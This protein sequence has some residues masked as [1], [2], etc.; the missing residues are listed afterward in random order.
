[1]RARHVTLTLAAALVPTVVAAQALHESDTQEPRRYGVVRTMLPPAATSTNAFAV[2]DFDGDGA[3]DIYATGETGA[4]NDRLFH[5]EGAGAFLDESWRLPNTSLPGLDAAASDLD[6]DGWCDLVVGTHSVSERLYR[7][8]GGVFADAS[9]ALPPDPDPTR[10]VAL[11][12]VDGDG[13]LDV[14]LGDELAPCRLYFNDGFGGFAD[15]SASIPSGAY[16][17]T[18]V[19]LGDVDGDGDLDAA[20]A[21]GRLCLGPSMQDRLYLNDGAGAFSEAT[22]RLPADELLT[23]AVALGDVDG[24]LDLDLLFADSGDC[25]SLGAHDRLYKNDGTGTFVDATADLASEELDTRAC[26]LGDVDGDG[27]LDALLGSLP[28]YGGGFPPIVVPGVTSLHRND[29]AGVFGPGEDVPAGLVEGSSCLALADV[30][31]DGDLDAFT[32]G[33]LDRLHLNDG[34]G[35]FALIECVLPPDSLEPVALGDVDADGHLDLLAYTLI[36]T[37]V[38]YHPYEAEHRLFLGDDAGYFAEAFGKL[39]DLEFPFA[40]AA[41]GDVDGDG[42]E[43]LLLACS[44]DGEY[45][46][47]VQDNLLYLS[48]GRGAFTDATDQLPTYVGD[49][50]GVAQCVR[51]ADVDDDGDLDAVFAEREDY[52]GGGGGVTL[53][54][55]D[56]AGWFSDATA[57]VACMLSEAEFVECGDVDADGDVDLVAG[58][59]PWWIGLMLNDGTG[60]FADGSAQLPPLAEAGDAYLFFGLGDVNGDHDLDI[61][62][63]GAA[64]Y[65]YQY[66][67]RL[68]ANDGAGVFVEAS[69]GMPQIADDYLLAD[70]DEDGDL[71]LLGGDVLLA[72]DGDGA[73]HVQP[74]QIPPW[75]SGPRRLGDVDGDGDLDA[76]VAMGGQDVVWSNLTRH[77]T[78][79]GPPRIGKSLALDVYG[80]P[81]TPWLLAVA[82]SAASLPLPP[83]GTLALDPALLSLVGSGSLDA[84]GRGTAYF[85]V[86]LDPGLV[87]AALQ[88]QALV[89]APPRFT[90]REVTVFTDL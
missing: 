36:P 69:A 64:L 85:S 83:Y 77:L 75:L 1:M 72:N 31:G 29:G 84:A 80:A 89:G 76:V 60:R 21:V 5:N 90:N 74:G 25:D 86:P 8:A 19:A 35:A 56:R 70:V 62:F 68:Y 13:D 88:W 54:R 14:W 58:G 22:D 24:D 63:G 59:F 6:G 52:D 18:D 40:D 46:P 7:N 50:R 87:G 44:Y 81:Q 78:W 53:F 41:L 79:R 43:D 10:A 15:A 3:P 34:A 11:G 65:S 39:P 33:G 30:D 67:G 23:A 48:D 4:P 73:F 2:L 61:V 32:G 16:R 20:L 27:D 42:D 47:L 55:N 38:P 82:P 17:V 49:D 57:D 26:A 9:S 12:D 66:E 71:D 37:Y 51:L 28:M 45:Y